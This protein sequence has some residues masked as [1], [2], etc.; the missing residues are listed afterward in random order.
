MQ[1]RVRFRGPLERLEHARRRQRGRQR[2][3][4]A[5]A[6]TRTRSSAKGLT[7]ASANPSA[8]SPM[9]SATCSSCIQDWLSVH[10]PGTSRHFLRVRRLLLQV[11]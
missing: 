4:A 10:Q 6:G 2:D 1:Q 3:R 5:W 11:K 9:L 8:C 7:A